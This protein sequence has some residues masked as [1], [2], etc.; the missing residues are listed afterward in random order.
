MFLIADKAVAMASE[1]VKEPSVNVKE[2]EAPEVIDVTP[3]PQTKRIAPGPKRRRKPGV[4]E[5]DEDEDRDPLDLPEGIKKE[6][7]VPGEGWRR[8]KRSE[9]V[10]VDYVGRLHSDGSQFDSSQDRGKPFGF[11]VGSG[12][13]IDG[14]D[15]AVKSMLKG[16][17]A[18]FTLQPE[19]AY[20]KKGKAPKIPPD[21]VLEFDIELLRWQSKDDLF[22]DE[23]CIK[24]KLQKGDNSWKFPKDGAEVCLCLV[25]KM[26][27]G[28]VLEE[29]DC[30]DYE[31]GSGSLGPVSKF[32]DKALVTMSRGE[33]CLL[34]GAK[35]YIYNGG[36][37]TVELHLVEVYNVRDVSLCRDQTVFLKTLDQGP[38]WQKPL[39]CYKVKI[40]VEEATDGANNPLPGFTAAELSWEC[41]D[42]EICDA[43]EGAV[44]QMKEG[45]RALVRCRKA[46]HAIEPKIGLSEIKAERVVYTIAVLE[47]EKGDVKELWNLDPNERFETS[48]K[49]KEIGTKLFGAKRFEFALDRYSQVVETL[50]DNEKFPDPKLKQKAIELRKA[51]ELNKAACRLKIGDWAGVMRAC[52]TVLGEDKL[53]VKAWF[54]RA[55]AL[56]ELTEYPKAIHDLNYVLELDP[57]NTDAK[58]Q[59]VISQKAQRVVDKQAQDTF[60]KMCQGLGKFNADKRTKQAILKPGQPKGYDPDMWETETESDLSDDDE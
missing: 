35:D 17:K 14:W 52:D 33:K 44:R 6:I 7:L 50:G 40:K 47:V 56:H 46:A 5:Q 23:G 10:K 19:F 49:Q 31:I 24:Q 13:V 3:A 25:G 43:L 20:G 1:E 32:L 53:N 55:K 38:G 41:G 28:K 36:K 16:E 22:G 54:R 21:A 8:P 42:G 45:E 12:R 29:H 59:L 60:A 57:K 39:D 4:P 58:A 51:A 30:V 18:K 15:F 48:L 27:D 26:E 37:S 2:E 9:K 11:T 34:H